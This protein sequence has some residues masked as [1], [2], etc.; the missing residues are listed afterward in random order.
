[1]TTLYGHK[2]RKRRLA[3][4]ARN[5]LCVM[6]EKE[7]RITAADTVDHKIPHKGD[8]TL[9]WDE[10]GNWQSLC[11][12]HHDQTKQREEIHGYSSEVDLSGWPVDPRHPVNKRK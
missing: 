3:F 2:W 1:M 10:A 8:L 11:K 9:F 6:C 4:L 7:G 5:P 12:P